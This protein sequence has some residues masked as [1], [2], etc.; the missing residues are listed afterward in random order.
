[1]SVI[2]EQKNNSPERQDGDEF[3]R[4]QFFVKLGVGSLVVTGAGTALFAYQYLSP[5]V[6]YEPPPVVD[7]GKPEQYPPDSMTLDTAKGIYLVR[8]AEGF[9]ALSAV[10]PHLGCLTVWKPELGIIACPCHGSK[11]HRDGSKIE[12]PAPKP[13]PWLRMWINDEGN[14]MVDRSTVLS[15]RQYIRV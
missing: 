1:M 9:Y 11:F 14:L 13:L 10:C 2:A 4:R 3:S 5:S 7:A 8:V 15:K 12:G 6:L